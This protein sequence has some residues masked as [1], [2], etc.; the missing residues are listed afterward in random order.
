MEIRELR[1]GDEQIVVAASHLFDGPTRIEAATRFLAADGHH[2]C[3]AFVEG[4]PA[5]F[6][7]GVE[8]THPNKGTEMFLYELGVD[9][10]SRRL[11]IG[12]ALTE[13]LKAVAQAVGCYGIWVITD[14][15]NLAA[16]ATYEG[17]GGVPEGDQVVEVWTF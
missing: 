6:I 11:G 3:I 17:S 12:R 15:D 9:E 10:A 5:G 1:A 4:R 16:R 2:L 13:H 8:M 7:S 14:Q